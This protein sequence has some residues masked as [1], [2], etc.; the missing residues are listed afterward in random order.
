MILDKLRKQRNATAYE[1][2]PVPESLLIACLDQA[3][4]L[5]PVIDR[6]MQEKGW[7]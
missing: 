5:L 1:A 7:A 6:R 4:L 3:R 2:D